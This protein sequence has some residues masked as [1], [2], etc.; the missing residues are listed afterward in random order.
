M[1]INPFKVFRA[2]ILLPIFPF[3]A[4]AALIMMDMGYF[5]FYYGITD[6]SLL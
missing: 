4:L 3:V 2:I 5:E 1:K 6:E